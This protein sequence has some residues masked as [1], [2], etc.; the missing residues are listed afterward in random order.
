MP[1]PES[2]DGSIAESPSSDADRYGL[3]TGLPGELII[4][5]SLFAASSS[6]STCR[7]LC[8][9]SSWI[10]VAVEPYLYSVFILAGRTRTD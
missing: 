7:A 10:R 9:V 6:S 8:L 3:F 1:L 4:E 2:M 5:I